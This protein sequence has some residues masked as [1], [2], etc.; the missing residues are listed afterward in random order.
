M[1]SAAST[2]T[3]QLTVLSSSNV[4]TT[5]SSVSIGEYVNFGVTIS[6]PHGTTLSPS[7]TFQLPVSVGAINLVSASVLTPSANINYPSVSVSLSDSNADGNNDTAT[8]AL[9]SVVN[10]P[11]GSSNITF[12][13]VALVLPSSSNTNGLQVTATSTLSYGN[14][15]ATFSET[16]HTTTITVVQPALTWAV[17]LNVSSGDAGDVV[18]YTV[19]VSHAAESASAAYD[20]AITSLLAPYFHLVSGS[21]STAATTGVSPLALQDGWDNIVYLP[22]LLLNSTATIKFSA[23]MDNSVQASSIITSQLV[24]NYSSSPSGGWNSYPIKNNLLVFII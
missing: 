14:G 18:G 22:T 12:Q 3:S 17:T 20:I 24:A 8:L 7:V 19:V 21:V 4:E 11:G 1:I 5:G 9:P 6:L 2:P 13:F 23:Y 15:T 16:A 10:N